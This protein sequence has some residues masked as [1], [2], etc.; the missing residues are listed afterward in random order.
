MAPPV[1]Q[2]QS[3]QPA[4]FVE[5]FAGS[6]GYSLAMRDAGFQV[7]AI[8]HSHNRFTS[9]V[10]IFTVDL[11]KPDEVA[12]AVNLLHLV[13]P[14]AVHFGLM[15]GACSR[16]RERAISR[17]LRAQGAPE[18]K[19]LRDE[20]HLLG[21]PNLSPWDSEKVHTAN[22]IYRHAVVLLQV[23]F[24]LSCIVSI[25]NPTR[26][27]L[28]PLM[29]KLIKE[30]NDPVLAEHYFALVAVCFDSCMH[31][32]LRA[33]STML[34]STAGVFESLALRCDHSH[35]HLP[36]GLTQTNGAWTFDTAAE[37]AYPSLLCVRLAACVVQFCGHDC[38]HLQY[39]Q[40]R[41][42]SLQSQGRQHRQQSQ[43]I[44]DFRTVDWRPPEAPLAPLDKLLLPKTAGE[45]NEAR[46]EDSNGR[47]VK[48]GTFHSHCEHIAA[49][50]TLSASF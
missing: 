27:W 3:H 9:K 14:K 33:K 31:G 32:G 2:V 40:L 45:I 12:V 28:W 38:L 8:D 20:S 39:N 17:H 10:P 6:A 46:G 4:A 49:A 47:L 43:L 50:L 7:F 42:T 35:S 5:F 34:L 29:A 48:V 41:M 44:P 36:W 37:A 1:Q 21:R 13:K 26:S 15:C 19:Q 25:E 24:A 23:C 22:L 16:A 30:A 11:S 18:P